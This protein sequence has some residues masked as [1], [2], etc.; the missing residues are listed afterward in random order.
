MPTRSF[1][2]IAQVTLW[3]AFEVNFACGSMV[4]LDHLCAV[5]PRGARRNRTAIK[6]TYRSAEGE[7]RPLRKMCKS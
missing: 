6:R 2:Y 4:P 1:L 5:F 3:P 7:K